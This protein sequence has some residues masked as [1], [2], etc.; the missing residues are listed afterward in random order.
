M[1][2]E[3]DSEDEESESA[4]TTYY[5]KTSV[6]ENKDGRMSEDL[7]ESEGIG[8]S[9]GYGEK[10]GTAVRE[11]LEEAVRAE[12]PPASLPEACVER[13]L[14]EAETEVTAEKVERTRGM[15]QA[16]EES[17]LPDGTSSIIKPTW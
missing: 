8:E 17:G 5:S 15:V 2:H 9:E 3:E 13:A 10:F 6:T 16:F 11:L 12:R 7:R 4:G 1:K 14:E